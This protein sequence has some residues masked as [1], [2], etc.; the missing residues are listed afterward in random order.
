MKV[1][2][3][4]VVK[5]TDEINEVL[6]KLSTHMKR[7]NI[8]NESKMVAD[9]AWLKLIQDP[10]IPDYLKNMT[11][12]VFNQEKVAYENSIE[13]IRDMKRDFDE[14]AEAMIRFGEKL[15]DE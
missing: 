8:A 7:A 15:V 9:L 1:E 2:L 11:Q 4:A 13:A 12:S 5:L 14:I 6:T 10:G 3:E